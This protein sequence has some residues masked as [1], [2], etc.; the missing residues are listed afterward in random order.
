[1]I[2]LTILRFLTI[3][4]DSLVIQVTGRP[5]FVRQH[6]STMALV[7]KDS[8]D[9]AGGPNNIPFLGFKLELCEFIGDLLRR[10]A[11]KEHEKDQPDGLRLVFVI[12]LAAKYPQSIVYI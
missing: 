5:C 8:N 7:L 2:T 4:F 1:M 6:I 12:N 10:I 3:V 9:R 11:V